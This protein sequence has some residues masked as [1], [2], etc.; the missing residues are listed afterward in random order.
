MGR[1]KDRRND[2]GGIPKKDDQRN[3]E[4]RHPSPEQSDER[5]P[6]HRHA[7]GRGQ[8]VPPTHPERHA[9]DDRDDRRQEPK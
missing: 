2:K 3:E 5:D 9:R 4:K 6:Q 8:D 7:P 1:E